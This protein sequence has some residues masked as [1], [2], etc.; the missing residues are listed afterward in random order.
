MLACQGGE[1]DRILRC[2]EEGS[3]CGHVMDLEYC[4]AEVGA[5]AD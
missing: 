4:G 3:A 5:C 2:Y 1:Q